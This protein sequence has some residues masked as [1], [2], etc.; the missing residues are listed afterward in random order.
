MEVDVGVGSE[1]GTEVLFYGCGMTVSIVEGYVAGHAHMHVDSDVAAYAAGAQ[2]VYL[3]HLILLQHEVHNL[4]LRGLGQALLKKLAKGFA[5]QGPCCA[6][7]EE[8]HDDGGNGIKHRPLVA[9]QQSTADA[10][11]RAYG[12]EGVA[13]VVPCVGHDGLRLHTPSRCCREPVSPLLEHYAHHSRHEGDDAR[14]GWCLT[15]PCLQHLLC[16]TIADHHSHEKQGDANDG[17]RQGFIFAMTVVV[18]AV[19]GLVAQPH[20][21]HDN[22]VGDEIGQ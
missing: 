22:D 16:P 18:V 3:A 15:L 1:V 20:E 2:M 11:A 14:H 17:C 4:F 10:Y 13:A 12:R 19:L 8:A 7:D 5:K 21:H 9:K 6:H